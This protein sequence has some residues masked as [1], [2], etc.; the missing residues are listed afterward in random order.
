MLPVSAG[1]V[2]V[3]EEVIFFQDVADAAPDAEAALW[4]GVGETASSGIWTVGIPLPDPG[5]TP[6]GRRTPAAVPKLT[7]RVKGEMGTLR[8]AEGASSSS[9]AF[10]SQSELVEVL[11][12]RPRPVALV[13]EV[14]P[15]PRV[16]VESLRRC[17]LKA[18][19]V[20]AVGKTGVPA[21]ELL[22]WNIWV[23]AAEV[24]EPRRLRCMS[25]G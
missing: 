23:K 2:C 10:S 9:M 20:M 8:V 18:A 1:C 13:G 3:V 17:S 22:R 4:G 25:A 24:M 14:P 11:A 19:V 16:V 6:P 21:V 5:L 12:R 15:M 7:R